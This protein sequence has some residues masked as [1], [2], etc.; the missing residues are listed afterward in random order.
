MVRELMDQHGIFVNAIAHPRVNGVRV[1]PGLCTS[2][3]DIDALIAALTSMSGRQ[4]S[5]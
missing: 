4:P 2:A 3:G 5:V 1:T